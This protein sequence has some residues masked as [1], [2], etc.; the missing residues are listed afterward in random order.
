MGNIDLLDL[1]LLIPESHGPV[2]A[3]STTNTS[4]VDEQIKNNPIGFIW[5]KKDGG[6]ANNTN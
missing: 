3:A 4:V 2:G 1:D 6:D 5:P